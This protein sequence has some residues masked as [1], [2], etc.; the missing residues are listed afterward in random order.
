MNGVLLGSKARWIADGEKA[1][2]YFCNLEKRNFISKQITKL[3]D[4]EGNI[5]DK[6]EDIKATVKRF[7]EGLYQK[8]SNIKCSI[9]DMVNK[10]PKLTE[11]QTD[12]IQGEITL[13]EA[14]TAL[15]NMKN[16]KSP[17]SDGFGAEFFKC[18]WKQIG[19]FVTRALNESFREGELSNTQ[20]EGII[21]CIPKEGKAKEYVKNWRPISLLNII[22]KIGSSCI[23]SRIK[24]VL[25]SLISEDQTGFVPSRYIGSN[26]RLIYDMMHYLN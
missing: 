19:V 22:Y 2:K 6:A 25:P 10:I 7:Y 13:E 11:E 18:F 23:A 4:E 12:S 9:E 3:L 8:R 21:I 1:S 17:G 15:K 26:I 16:G 24:T 20:K 14:G 5:L